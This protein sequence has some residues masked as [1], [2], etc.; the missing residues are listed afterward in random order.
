MNHRQCADILFFSDYDRVSG[1][2][3]RYNL[4]S[5]TKLLS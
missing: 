4:G 1:H 5:L 3:R 2:V